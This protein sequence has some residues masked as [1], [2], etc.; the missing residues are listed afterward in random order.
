MLEN[1]KAG[2][3]EAHYS[4]YIASWLNEGGSYFGK[5]FRDWLASEGLSENEIRDV[6][7]LATCGKLELEYSAKEYVK[8]YKERKGL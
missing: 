7:E 2:Q 5:E 3:H 6:M 1:K 8:K 4:R